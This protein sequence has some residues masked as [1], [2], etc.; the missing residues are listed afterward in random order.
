LIQINRSGR[1]VL[2]A[3]NSPGCQGSAESKAWRVGMDALLKFAMAATMLTSLI[4]VEEAHAI[5]L[6]G[7]WATNADQC[8]QVFIRKG[9]ANQIGF[10]ALSQQHGGGFIIEANRLRG[11]FASC[12]IKTMKEDG[13]TVNIIAGCATDIM[14]SNVQF[15][16][17]VLE[18]NKISRT[19]PGMQDM[20]ISYYRCPI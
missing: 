12:K 7:A 19:F 5:D 17:K 9:R 2:S 13:Q 11:K 14:L 3:C 8:S 20:E 1:I 16:L 18:S 15:N 4:L 6:S 10:T